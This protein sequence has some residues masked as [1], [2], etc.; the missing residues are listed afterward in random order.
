MRLQGQPSMG[1]G[2]DVGNFQQGENGPRY[3]GLAYMDPSIDMGEWIPTY[4]QYNMQFPEPYEE[5]YPA[6]IGR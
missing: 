2:F 3:D 4:P 1:M 5:T 6:Q